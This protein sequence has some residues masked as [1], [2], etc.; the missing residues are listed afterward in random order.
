M[1]DG[2]HY[3][4]LG[5]RSDAS[6]DEIRSA[7]REL[8]RRHHPDVVGA[9]A[10]SSAASRMA[11]INRAWF[12]LGDPGRRAVYDAEIAGPAS[13]T[14]PAAS[15]PS[16]STISDEEL[17]RLRNNEGPARFPWRFVLVL[18]ALATAGI[19][20]LGMFGGDSEPT[21]VDKVVQVGSCVEVDEVLREAVEV[22]CG[23]PHD[24]VVSHLVP[25]DSVCPSGTIGY[26]DRQGMGQV[27]LTA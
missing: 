14:S 17:R 2:V 20:V 1:N 7:Y 9:A 22:D 16:F 12:V 15:S 18:I 3:R 25:F 24:G 5:V 11:A 8:A 19:L 26:R 13:R 21:P 4:T 23:A 10:D 27:C 6:F